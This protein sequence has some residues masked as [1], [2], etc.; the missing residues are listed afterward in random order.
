MES[1]AMQQVLESPEH[2]TRI[3]E[4]IQNDKALA[5]VRSSLPSAARVNSWW[6]DII[7]RILWAEPPAEALATVRRRRRQIYASHIKTL[8][9][10]FEQDPTLNTLFGGLQFPRLQKLVLF[11]CP[12]DRTRNGSLGSHNAWNSVVSQYLRP[13]L[14]ILD[15]NSCDTVCTPAFFTDVAARCPRLKKISIMRLGPQ[16]QA[17][18]LFKFFEAC[19]RLV[20]ISLHF[21]DGTASSLVTTEL[22]LCFSR[23]EKLKSFEMSW[24]LDQWEAFQMIKCQNSA[25]FPSLTSISLIVSSNSVY[26]VAL[27]P[28]NFPNPVCQIAVMPS[29]TLSRGKFRA[30]RIPNGLYTRETVMKMVTLLW[31]LLCH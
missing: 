11:K 15:M 21:S 1:A 24:H 16:L 23:M 17:D 31:R 20:D 29:P 26:S 22:L 3:C 6:R 2:L 28:G 7:Y 30:M 25:P 9:F 27:Q 18:N 10:N 5:L 8:G 4:I 12:K 13:A 14:E 19:Q